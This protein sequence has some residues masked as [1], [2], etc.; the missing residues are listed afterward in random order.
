MQVADVFYT[1]Q[2]TS[3]ST[4]QYDDC[5]PATLRSYEFDL[6]RWFRCLHRQ[7]TPWERAEREDVRTFVEW[8]REAPNPQRT[9]RRP[10]APVPGS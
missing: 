2:Q 7:L 6:L 3:D 4:I 10:D 9:H 1:S 5:S 8:L